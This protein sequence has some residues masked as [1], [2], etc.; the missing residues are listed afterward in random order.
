MKV[1]LR[2]P[3]LTRTGYGEHGRCVLRALQTRQ[4]LFDIY[5][6]PLAWGQ[7]SWTGEYTEERAW[8]DQAIEKT[9]MHAQSGGTFDVTIQVTIPN[10]FEK[11]AP[12]NIGVTA[13]METTLVSPE[14]IQRANTMDKVIVVSDHSKNVFTNTIYDAVDN[15]TQQQVKIALTTPIATVGY[16]VKIFDNL[17]EL[18][19][20][21]K[22][23]FNFLTVAQVSPR[24]NVENTIQWFFEEFKDDE[25]G[26]V[27]KGN[28]AKNSLMDRVQIEHRLKELIR[29]GNYGDYK[30][31]LYLLHGDMTDAE[32][33]SLYQHPQ[34]KAL[35]TLA[36]GEGF[37]LPVFEAAYSGIPV[38]APGYSGYLDFLVDE[39]KNE[40][41]YDVGFDLNKVQKEAV[42]EN[43]IVEES[44][45]AYAR[46]QSAK[47]K[48]RLCYDDVINNNG[49]ASNACDYAQVLQERFKES[50]I[51]EKFVKE[52]GLQAEAEWLEDMA[53][54]EIL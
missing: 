36:H 31:K 9:I 30:C 10:E 4:D 49:H 44:M 19:L 25:V 47:E 5:I 40:H 23:D 53:E 42:W 21:L 54:I 18:D 48:M 29:S 33:H 7:T 32:M 27:L 46:E 2:S 1:L 11:I 3:V 6:Q 20:E 24:K 15:R 26:L 14:W 28:F 35:L 16:P 22:T 51:Y 37:G 52:L 45:W 39:D 50:A 13:G 41:F 8:I 43:I 34:I 17:P 38:I 12:I